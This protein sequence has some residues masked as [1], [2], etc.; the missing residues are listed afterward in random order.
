M[1]IESAIYAKMLLRAGR[2]FAAESLGRTLP[3]LTAAVT[4]LPLSNLHADTAQK[5]ETYL[6]SRLRF[7]TSSVNP[8]NGVNMGIIR[9]KLMAAAG[10]IRM[11]QWLGY[12]RQAVQTE[13]M[14][15]KDE[16]ERSRIWGYSFSPSVRQRMLAVRAIGNLHRPKLTDPLL[17][18]LLLDPS[19]RVRLSVMKL[20]RIIPPD[21]TGIEE[22]YWLA[23]DTGSLTSMEFCPA[24]RSWAP[25]PPGPQMTSFLNSI[26]PHYTVPHG[27]PR[28]GHRY[29]FHLIDRQTAANLLMHHLS[30]L[31]HLMSAQIQYDDRRPLTKPPIYPFVDER[32]AA[33]TRA[34]CRREFVH[35]LRSC[36]PGSAEL[37][38]R[39]AL[40]GKVGSYRRFNWEGQRYFY[41]NRTDAIALAL[42]VLRRPTASFGLVF[43]GSR[44]GEVRQWAAIS[45][46]DQ[47]KARNYL[48]RWAGVHH[49]TAYSPH[50]SN[51]ESIIPPKRNYWGRIAPRSPMLDTDALKL[52]LIRFL[53]WADSLPLKHKA[54]EIQWGCGGNHI[55]A[56]S[57][58]FRHQPRAIQNGMRV[59]AGI[60]G[61]P[62]RTLIAHFIESDHSTAQSSAIHQA[63]HLQRQIGPAIES[64][65]WQAAVR[66]VSSG[67]IRYLIRHDTIDA[68][69]A[70][71]AMAARILMRR[72]RVYM[73]H[74]LAHVCRRY[75]NAHAGLLLRVSRSPYQYLVVMNNLSSMFAISNDGHLRKWMLR[76][77]THGVEVRRQN[78][79]LY[80]YAYTGYLDARTVLLY[81]L[82]TILKLKPSDYGLQP[83]TYF[84][85]IGAFRW[86]SESR[87]AQDAACR[88]LALAV[89]STAHGH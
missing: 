10:S 21:K 43:A 23:I 82:C 51:H 37:V 67:G 47:Q 30:P 27:Y 9:S 65:L 81:D 3:G 86:M 70:D 60:T 80:R 89:A 2:R 36:P 61:K 53:L 48:F 84:P 20:L 62:A 17:D 76:V 85:L 42:A 63:A 39:I 88:R 16:L 78:W 34:A 66:P 22:L 8:P 87:A 14:N 57:E 49:L 7:E 35:L 75:A 6:H 83:V 73:R 46:R 19:E 79:P 68:L 55:E 28:Y 32:S 4:L 11:T 29:Y 41:N 58:C 31:L 12:Q 18:T 56:V 74:M 44:L 26:S 52:G 59:V 72:G 25:Y 24:S 33:P 13:L 50:T 5:L 54:H 64:A 71:S 69:C 15:A 77:A 38:V 1:A 45:P 40:S